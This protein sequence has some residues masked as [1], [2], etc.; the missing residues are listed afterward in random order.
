MT[1]CEVA[2]GLCENQFSSSSESGSPTGGSSASVFWHI[3]SSQQVGMVC[4]RLELAHGTRSVTPL[5]HMT[6]SEWGTR[7][8][9]GR[10]I[11][12]DGSVR[13]ICE[14]GH[15]AIGISGTRRSLGGGRGA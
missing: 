6:S 4:H 8:K 15:T 14:R 7:D 9:R 2:I 1:E 10:R 12:K 13:T 5:A 11:G 3:P